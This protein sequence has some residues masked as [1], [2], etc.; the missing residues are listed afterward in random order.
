V[1]V[2]VGLGACSSNGKPSS[3]PPQTMAPEAPQAAD[4]VSNAPQE[5]GVEPIS[6]SPLEE[7]APLEEPTPTVEPIAAA[8]AAAAGEDED[9]VTKVIEAAGDDGGA[10]ETSLYAAARAERERRAQTERSTLVLDDETLKKYSKS[11]LTEAGGDEAAGSV[12]GDEQGEGEGD[13][14]G[15]IAATGAGDHAST[16]EAGAAVP[17]EDEATSLWRR[18]QY[19]R[20]RVLDLR[21]AWRNSLDRIV[22]LEEEAAGLRRDFYAEDDP[23]YRDSQIKP[24]WDRALDEI[25][26]EKRA[27]ERHE[28]EL[29]DSLDEGH[30]EGALPGWLREGIELEPTEEEVAE[31]L[32]RDGKVYEPIEPQISDDDGR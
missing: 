18:E 7:P 4:P 32:G 24:A 19:W 20:N 15:S 3:L 14:V 10:Q 11:S 22:E 1:A 23:F 9:P 31:T 28:R 13:P 6:N 17:P 5:L 21:Q 29:A 27:A 30:R 26:E 16:P 2:A 12:A 25:E 8:G